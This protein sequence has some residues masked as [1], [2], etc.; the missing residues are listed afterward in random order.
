MGLDKVVVNA[1]AIVTLIGT[2]AFVGSTVSS[3]LNLAYLESLPENIRNQR[4][5]QEKIKDWRD[6]MHKG[7]YF[8]LGSAL[9]GI[10][11]TYGGLNYQNRRKIT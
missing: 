7:I 2:L 9:I 5:T 3:A 4:I 8:G 10:G 11:V 6:G 1:G